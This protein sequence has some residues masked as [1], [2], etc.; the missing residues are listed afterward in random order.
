MRLHL[1]MDGARFANACANVALVAAQHP[2]RILLGQIA[3]KMFHRLRRQVI[4]QVGMHVVGN[5]V[6]ID[7]SADHIVLQSRFID[8]AAAERNHFGSARP[9]I[10]DP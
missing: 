5:V 2:A 8:A 10:F 7:E 3:L 9:Q 6:E 1:H 4:E